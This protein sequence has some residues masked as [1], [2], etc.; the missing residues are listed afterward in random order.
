MAFERSVLVRRWMPFL[1]RRYVR[2]SKYVSKAISVF[3]GLGALWVV[4]DAFWPNNINFG[5]GDW[6]VR[7]PLNKQ[8]CVHP[9]M[10][11]NNPNIMQYL[12]KVPPISCT[13]EDWVFTR[14]GRV[15]ISDAAVEQH[16]HISC[17]ITYIYMDGND[18]IPARSEPGILKD[19][20]LLKHDS[21]I[22]K[23]TA[24]D[25]QSHANV[26]S[27]IARRNDIKPRSKPNTK[28]NNRT[29]TK[30]PSELNIVIWGLDSMSSLMIQRVLPKAHQYFTETLGGVLLEGYNVAGDGTPQN[31]IP[32]L[33]GKKEFDL[34]DVRKGEHGS[35]TVDVYPFVWKEYSDRG[36]VTH[37]AEED[38]HIGMWNYRLNGFKKQPTHHYSR[39]FYLEAQK[40]MSPFYLPM[41]NRP[42][43][44]CIGAR[45]RPR[46]MLDWIKESFETYEDIPKF[47]AFFNS[48]ITHEYNN[49][50]QLFEP[51]LLEFFEFMNTNGHLDNTILIIMSDHGARFNKMRATEQGKLEERMPYF[52][53]RFPEW[54]RT[55]YETKYK[56][57]VENSYR[58]T[59]PFDIHE[60][61]I[62]LLYDFPEVKN[63]TYGL[64]LFEPIPLERTCAQAEI[65]PHWC[66][67]LSWERVSNDN[68]DAMSAV[69]SVINIIN[70]N[71]KPYSTD[72]ATLTL[73]R[74]KD[75]SRFSTNAD[76][77]KF[78]RTADAE[79]YAP[80]L[81][82]TMQALD[83]L[84]LVTFY[85]QPR[86]GLFE[87]T[88]R[89]RA[90]DGQFEAD[91]R[92]ISRLNKYGDDSWCLKEKAARLL[93][94]CVCKIPKSKNR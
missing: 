8:A 92:Q 34:P 5:L 91:I 38:P 69:S 70:A 43:K 28:Y 35:T 61:L 72:C 32:I 64:S 27:G 79:G 42:S 21:F 75:A 94:Y 74:V 51:Y 58:L 49:L 39:P 3:I 15:Y 14:K 40:Y 52:G 25:G 45:P 22:V 37:F 89:K 13:D 90:M 53:F 17:E 1:W 65:E 55:V 36:Y 57:F 66:A 18:E 63:K 86:M 78:R 68:T 10:P 46:L 88:V 33:T 83:V 73:S 48:E 60:T 12:R 80:D 62:D 4:F 31:W 29:F 30:R 44:F 93:L 7:R 24:E 87:A 71:L 26:H 76:V 11:V 41:D 47:F 77:L 85:T 19:G 50:A 82:D 2:A 9:Q 54:F 56:A 67:C 6:T 84:Y 59:T 16:G 81:G 23:C 20:S